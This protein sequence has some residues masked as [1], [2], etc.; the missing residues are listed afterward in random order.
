MSE[1]WPRNHAT[2]PNSLFDV[3][4]LVTSAVQRKRDT[5]FDPR[6]S[7]LIVVQKPFSEQRILLFDRRFREVS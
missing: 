3:G 2:A 4:I 1:A 5:L 6:L 7:G